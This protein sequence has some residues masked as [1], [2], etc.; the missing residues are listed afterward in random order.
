LGTKVD[1]KEVRTQQKERLRKM[2]MEAFSFRLKMPSTFRLPFD[3]DQY[4]SL[5]LSLG[6]ISL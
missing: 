6:R 3:I 2:K 4:T 1:T 5:L